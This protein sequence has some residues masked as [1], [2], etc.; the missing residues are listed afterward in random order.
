MSDEPVVVSNPQ[1][2]SS[3]L[4]Q[5][6][7]MLKAVGEVQKTLMENMAA[8]NEHNLS[9]EA[10]NDLRKI[11]DNISGMES[12]VTQTGVK[13]WIELAVSDHSND[14]WGAGHPTI[15]QKINSVIAEVEK[16]AGR[17]DDLAGISPIDGSTNLEVTIRTI[18]NKYAIILN[19]LQ[20]AFLEAVGP[21]NENPDPVLGASIQQLISETLDK[22]KEEILKAM[23]EQ[24]F[25]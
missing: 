8:I 23:S 3:L 5:C 4:Q 20:N 22:K 15:V 14:A 17:I 11:L 10:H 7:A 6:L 24:E 21:E 18:E 16:L 2:E 9:P 19:S 25:A 13:Q 1:S 12:V